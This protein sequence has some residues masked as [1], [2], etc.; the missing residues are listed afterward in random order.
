MKQSYKA[1]VSI[2]GTCILRDTFS[3]QGEKDGRYK[4]EKYMSRFSPLSLCEPPVSVDKKAFWAFDLKNARFTISQNAAFIT[5]LPI[6]LCRFCRKQSQT[7]FWSM[8]ALCRRDYFQFGEEK[9]SC[10]GAEQ[11]IFDDMAKHHVLPPVTNVKQLFDFPEEE[12]ERRMRYY[13]NQLLSLYSLVRLF[14]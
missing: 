10:Y 8:A 14:Y 6:P 4:I 12:I 3:R 11:F 2:A 9:Y 1:T 5:I 7:G 13:V